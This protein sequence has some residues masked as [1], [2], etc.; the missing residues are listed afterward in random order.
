M[1]HPGLFGFGPATM[2][3]SVGEPSASSLLRSAVKSE[4]ALLQC[5]QTVPV[6]Q[7]LADA[8]AAT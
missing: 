5:W 4:A 1:Y 3:Q 7:Q 2:G 8:T 6:Q